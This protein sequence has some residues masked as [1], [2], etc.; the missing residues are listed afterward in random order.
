[1]RALWNLPGIAEAAPTAL[2][3]SRLGPNAIAHLAQTPP[4][5]YGS[6]LGDTRTPPRRHNLN[7]VPLNAALESVGLPWRV[8]FYDEPWNNDYEIVFYKVGVRAED[9]LCAIE[10]PPAMADGPAFAMI[11]DTLRAAA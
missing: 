11:C 10:V 4:P 8:Q 6:L 7:G 2:S 1:M 5:R 3:L 9:H